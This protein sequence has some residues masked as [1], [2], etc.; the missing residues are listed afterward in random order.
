MRK[1]FS[2]ALSACMLLFALLPASALA[3]GKGTPP[4]K[5]YEK[6]VAQKGDWYS[7]QFSYEGESSLIVGYRG[8]YEKAG[9]IF[10]FKFNIRENTV[11]TGIYIP[12][13]GIAGAAEVSLVSDQGN[14]Y[15]G[16]T[17][18]ITYTNKLKADGDRETGNEDELRIE[19]R[20]GNSLA[21]F[22]PE[23]ALIL[24]KGQYAIYLNTEGWPADAFLI[25]GINYTAYEK[26]QAGLSQWAGTDKED[27]EAIG[28]EDLK[29]DLENIFEG[30]EVEEPLWMGLPE[31]YKY[32][33]FELDDEYIITEI[34]LSTWNNGE[35]VMPG[36]VFLYD[37]NGDLV[38]LFKAQ[39]YSKGGVP[40]T[41]WVAM[42]EIQLPAGRYF[43]DIEDQ[44]A[45]DFDE[46]GEPLFY[47]S[48]EP[49]P[50]IPASFT[51]S[52]RIDLNLM[53][54]HTLMG[55]VDPPES[56]FSLSQNLIAVI[57]KGSFIEIIGEY[58][59]MPFSQNCKVIERDAN[60]AIAVLSFGADLSGLPYKAKISAQGKIYFNKEANGRFTISIEG[61]G[62]FDR[63]ASKDKGADSNTY[64]LSAKGNKVKDSLPTYVM[65][66]IG[67]AFGAGN[68][69]GPDT[70]L[71]AATG[72][73]F[74]PLVGLIVSALQSALKPKEPVRKLSVGE[75]AMKDA[76]NSLG[77]GLVSDDEARAW[78]IMADALGA[79]GG[80]EGDPISIG[81]NERAAA[82]GGGSQESGLFGSSDDDSGYD[83]DYESG[84]ETSDTGESYGG[85][86]P[87]YGEGQE[88]AGAETYTAPADTGPD[89]IELVTD[90]K[91]TK[92]TYVKD[93][94]TGEYV[95]PLTGGVLDREAYEKI[96][97]P[98]FA[99]DKEFIEKEWEKVST[100]QTSF[101]KALREAEAQRKAALAHEELLIKLGKKYGTSNQ[102]EL[103]KIIAK[104][105]EINRDIAAAWTRAANVADA[106][107][108][109]A[110]VT[111]V[112]ADVALDGLE[113]VTG[114][115]GK[116]IN[117]TYKFTKNVAGTMAED[118]ISTSS[119]ARGAIKGG[120][121]VAGGF[122]DNPYAKAAVTIGAETAAGAIKDGWEGA[123]GGFVEGAINV[124]VGSAIDK[125]AGKGFGNDVKTMAVGTDKVRVAVKSGDTW[126]GKVL[127]TK[128][129][130]S[131]V[132]NKYDALK[133]NVTTKL[134][135]GVINEFGIKPTV[136]QPLSQG[137]SDA[138]KNLGT[139]K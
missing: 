111:V 2:L 32:P 13:K 23:N 91:G 42:P 8:S 138:V 113:Q 28:S 10:N 69:P 5:P 124:G 39:G 72:I 68:I 52:Y 84:Y 134:V 31:I 63:A 95:N 108:K 71:E 49:P 44:W 41:L 65:A 38:D 135:G 76:N 121:D 33:A 6:M 54:T 15:S 37:G 64:D 128:S 100:G 14:I 3:A 1:L 136:T 114:P 53:K 120:A 97:Q 104:Q 73:L 66:A 26:Y 36:M 89:E 81:D 74:P 61:E 126:V 110:S 45:L 27:A 17:A 105:N 98:G 51:G 75:Q 43:L 90:Y 11:L 70:P 112:I 80:D 99:A 9:D 131:F 57:D 122:I 88:A 29:E 55:P 56:A 48:V 96:V 127:S 78:A 115:A 116:V 46:N 125:F 139:T 20:A 7:S 129:A 77:K 106:G 93:P 103:E 4:E 59:N 101:D 19:E 24:P 137:A 117:N 25:K 22:S 94:V 102:E 30:K 12:L 86:A 67:A 34:V 83:S 130:N 87:S 58:E 92:T 118:G 119:L 107:E 123:A 82:D 85:D 60:S 79:S 35:G 21:Y 16:F 62:F 109:L 133:K 40:N 47:V 50:E 18:E 132:N